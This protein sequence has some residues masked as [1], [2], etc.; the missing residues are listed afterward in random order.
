VERIYGADPEGMHIEELRLSRFSETDP[1]AHF[2]S[3]RWDLW[4]KTLPTFKV[5]IS[6]FCKGAR[7]PSI[8]N[9]LIRPNTAAGPIEMLPIN[10]AEV[11][12]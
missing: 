3:A 6:I 7:N 11:V 5:K 4:W 12:A 1:K 10:D 8:S 2:C 9:F